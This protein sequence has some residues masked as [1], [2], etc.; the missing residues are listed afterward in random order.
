MPQIHAKQVAGHNLS[1]ER[2]RGGNCHLGSRVG[3]E[4]GT[5]FTGNG[6]ALGVTNRE[7][8]GSALRGVAN[9]H[10]SV[11]GFTGLADRDHQGV[12]VN[13]WLAVT[14]LVGELNANRNPRPLFNRVHTDH[15]GVGGRPAGDKDNPVDGAAIAD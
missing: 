15:R 10:Q 1:K 12:L 5:G 11:H 7:S 4:R 6:G 2:L 14:E 9:G 8:L 13:S 3:I